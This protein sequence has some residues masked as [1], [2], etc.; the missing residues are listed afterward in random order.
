MFS[1]YVLLEFLN[2][3]R[4]VLFDVA[5][6]AVFRDI[7]IKNVYVTMRTLSLQSS[8]ARRNC[9]RWWHQP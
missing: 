9:S 7:I 3:L 8:T 2:I 6:I 1:R 4:R 5:F